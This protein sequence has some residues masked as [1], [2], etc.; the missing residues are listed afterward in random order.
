MFFNNNKDCVD[1][2]RLI[3]KAMRGVIKSALE[4]IKKS[5]Y[6]KKYC[7]MFEVDTQFDGVV[8]QKDVLSQYPKSITLIIQYQFSNLIIFDDYFSVDLSFGGVVSNVKIPFDSIL[9]FSDKENGFEIRFRDNA[10]DSIDD[11]GFSVDYEE[12][13]DETM[14]NDSHETIDVSDSNLINFNDLKSER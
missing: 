13:C 8:L 10:S 5:N 2:N 11:D 14:E 3:E 12:G 1:Y 9:A 7:F 4:E 6:K